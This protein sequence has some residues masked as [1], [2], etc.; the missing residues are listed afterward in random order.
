MQPKIPNINKDT[1]NTTTKFATWIVGHRWSVIA[2]TV[3]IVAVVAAGM[4][5]A[6]F[7]GDYH[8]FFAP[9]N[10]QMLAFE[11]LENTYSKDDNVLIVLAPKNGDV[12]TNKTLEVVE[13]IT[14][15]GWQVPYSSRVDSISNFQYTK[16]TGDDLTVQ[17][18]YEDAPGL[19]KNSIA[20]IKSVALKEPQLVNKLLSPDARVTGI[21]ITVQLPGV[22]PQTEMPKITVAVNEIAEQIRAQNPE[23]DVYMT[24][25]VL[26]NDA[27]FS[28]SMRD[29]S[30]LVPLTFLVVILTVGLF[31]R[32]WT[33]TFATLWIILL[34]ITVG[35]GFSGWAGIKLT[36]PSSV[37]PTIIMTLAVANAIHILV[38]M[39][40][41]MRQGIE[42]RAAVV[43]SLRVNMQP[44]FLTSL[45]TI[46]GFLAMN[47][48]E[49]PP[50]QDLGNIVAVGMAASFVL[51]V[52]FLP[53]LM[54][55]LP[56]R[57]PKQQVDGN[58][59]ML[60]LAEFVIRRRTP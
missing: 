40:H 51:S 20:N 45:S 49:S 60:K 26:L 38:S 57:V 54:A 25:I 35:M 47:F 56:V 17:D 1:D 37:A 7:T 8:V 42:K 6:G 12:F 34:S 48:S 36:P 27:F 41:A 23:I 15:M 10:P 32:S 44:V 2:L 33:S 53:A 30:T 52:T 55:L 9:D 22:S 14:K 18:L 39:F 29:M 46:I 58:T 11:L 13:R 59:S 24:G 19:S 3:M 21:N 4:R 50:F 31:L 5:H 28:S 16:A 43:E